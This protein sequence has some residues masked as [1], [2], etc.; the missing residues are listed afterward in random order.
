MRK[1]PAYLQM[2]ATECGAVSLGMVMSSW[3]LHVS[4]EEL[5]DVCGVS[6]DGS[7]AVSILRAARRYGFESRGL[8][9][10]DLDRLA[11]FGV[12]LILFWEFNHF[13]VFVG[14]RGGRFVVTIPR[15]ANGS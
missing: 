14:R 13:V 4:P 10:P 12:P 5:R 11:S 9:E 6:R 3:G 2:E 7:N 8:K 1:V 15:S